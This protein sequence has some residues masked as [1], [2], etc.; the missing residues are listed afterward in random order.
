MAQ[1][2]WWKSVFSRPFVLVAMLIALVLMATLQYSWAD[3]VSVSERERMHANLRAGLERLSE[4]FDRELAR[5]YLTFQMDASTLRDAA[6]DRYAQRYDLWQATAP[7]AD[8][9]EQVF[10]VEV[11]D[12][13]RL[14]LMRFDPETRRFAQTAWPQALRPLEERFKEAYLAL[15]ENSPNTSQSVPKPVA[16]DV[17]ALVI[18]ISRIWMLSDQQTDINADLIYGDALAPQTRRSCWQCQWT[19]PSVSLSAYTIVLLDQQ[20]LTTQFIPALVQR[21]FA[22]GGTLDYHVAIVSRSDP[23]TVVYRSG[24]DVPVAN[25]TSGDETATIFN[26]RLDELSR[27]LIDNAARQQPDGV[28]S[29]SQTERLAIGILGREADTTG[30]WQITLTHREGSLEA[31]VANLRTRNLAISFGTLLLLALGVL[32]TVMASQRA[33]RLAQQQIEFVAGVSH[34]FRTPLAVI[35]SASEN[36]A[37]GVVRDAQHARRYGAL[38]HDEGRRLTVMVEQALE[39]AGAQSGRQI[40]DM[41]ATDVACVVEA[42]LAACQAAFE[43]SGTTIRMRITPNLPLVL[44]DAAALQRSLQNL[45]TNAVKYGGAS[46]RIELDVDLRTANRRSEL[47]IMVRDHGPG[48][49][50]PDLPH[51][52]EP[53]Y[54]G[55]EVAASSIHGSGLGLSLVKH[56]VTAHGG[57]IDV[58][59]TPERGT[60][61]TVRLPCLPA[62]D[63][64]TASVPQVST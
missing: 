6:W 25:I 63:T 4:D 16:E 2:H 61:F 44:A 43:K 17:S 18:P 19:A 29:G 64:A 60:T 24:D 53:F 35:C 34:E 45:L 8:L 12:H 15:P 46:P 30:H 14:H 10:L 21:Y 62:D 39:F 32:I 42:A 37:D 59:S 28:K 31:A 54:R 7:Y 51:I 50:S 9:V 55:R 22:S 20:Y 49:A 13:G 57:Q 26:V 47:Q 1:W 58:H 33:Q 56:I 36:L 3:R 5:A 41:R 48:I 38:I 40:Y 52:F 27:M 11:Y 23:R